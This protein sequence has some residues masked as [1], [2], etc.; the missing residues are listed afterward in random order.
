MMSI[1]GTVAR[2][3]RTPMIK[4]GDC[5]ANIVVD[6]IMAAAEEGFALQDRD[7]IGITES[8]VAR[9]Q[10]NYATTAQI[11]V[12][13]MNKFGGDEMAIVFPILSRNRFGNIL[14]GVATGCKK[15]YIL[16]SYPADEVGNHLI[17]LD[18]L[19]RVS[20]NPYTDVLDERYYR[21]LFGFDTK[22][23]FTGIDYVEYYKSFGEHIEIIFAND[24]REILS[25]TKK[26]LACDIHT[27]Q[28]TKNLLKRA[29]AETVYGLDDILTKSIG[30]SGYNENYGLL[31]SNMATPDK[32]K[33]FPRDCGR[34]VEDI[35]AQLLAKTGKQIEVMVYGD[36][37]FKDPVGM[38]WEL[39]DPVVSPAYTKGLVGTPNELKLKFMLDN[40]LAGKTEAEARATMTAAIKAKETELG[41]KAL[42]TTPRHYVDLLGSLCDLVSGSGD[43]GT[44]IVLVQGYFRDYAME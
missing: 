16:L 23:P 14:K 25:Y 40:E 12:D 24:P 4:E 10:G 38:I 9:A 41:D 26:V 39:A 42:G 15:L 18:A 27:R 29:G 31:G 3:I 7:V 20:V 21:E 44:P 22:H 30:N 17:D 11:A 32:I 36:G 35:Q 5:L 34:L 33:L 6:C 1:L 19:N 37:A 28:R 13:V 43:K 2:G 8:V